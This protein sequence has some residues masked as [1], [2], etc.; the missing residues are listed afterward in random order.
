VDPST[1]TIVVRH[2]VPRVAP[3]PPT[4][5]PAEASEVVTQAVVG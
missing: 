5:G 4:F 2:G 1:Q 3:T